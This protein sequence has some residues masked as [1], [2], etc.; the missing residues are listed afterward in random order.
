MRVLNRLNVFPSFVRIYINFRCFVVGGANAV[1]GLMFMTERFLLWWIKI[2]W[3]FGGVHNDPFLGDGPFFSVFDFPLV[4]FFS[5]VRPLMNQ[6]PPLF[7]GI[8][9]GF[10]PG[11]GPFLIL[12]LFLML[13]ILLMM[14]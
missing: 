4:L 13:F 10:Y 7:F 2:P 6:T 9:D 8:H 1:H 14:N 5:L 3:C 12:V 11:V